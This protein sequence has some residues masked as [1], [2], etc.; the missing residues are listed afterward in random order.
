MGVDEAL[1]SSAVAGGCPTLRLY[2]WLGAVALARLRAT[3]R[4]ERRLGLRRAG[5]GVVRRVTGGRAVYSTAAISPTRSRRAKRPCCRRGCTPPTSSWPRPCSAALA[6]SGSTRRPAP[7]LAG[8]FRRGRAGPEGLRLLRE[9]AGDELCVGGRKLV[10]SAQR[11][12]GGG[13]LQHGSIRLQPDPPA[14]RRAA[15]LADGGGHEPPG[16]RLRVRPGGPGRRPV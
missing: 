7:R 4:G 11:R 13:V 3:L 1:L 5:V 15:G 8:R 12:A 9:P 2:R 10:G 16:A 6:G 14:I